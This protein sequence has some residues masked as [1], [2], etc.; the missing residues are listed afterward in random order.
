M[1]NYL[2]K[3]NQGKIVRESAGCFLNPPTH[4]EYS[5]SVQSKYGDTFFMSLRYAITQDWLDDDSKAKARS[6]L[7]NW[8]RP[9]LFSKQVQDW[10]AEVHHYFKNGWFGEDGEPYFTKEPQDWRDSMAVVHIRQW[11]P[12]YKPTKAIMKGGDTDAVVQEEQADS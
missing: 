11:Y 12:E 7:R 2:K 9:P 8:K 4:P 10:I 3:S 5:Y 6:L 1:A